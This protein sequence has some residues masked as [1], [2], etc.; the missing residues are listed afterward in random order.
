[1]TQHCALQRTSLVQNA[2]AR[3]IC[4]ASLTDTKHALLQNDF[5][6]MAACFEMPLNIDTFEGTRTVRNRLEFSKL[7]DDARRYYQSIGVTEISRSCVEAAFKDE[8]TVVA[9]HETRLLN[10]T[11]TLVDPYPVMAE[12]KWD[13]RGWKIVRNSYGLTSTDGLSRALHPEAGAGG[14][15]A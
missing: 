4:E 3:D 11:R 14:N 12:M 9:T 1:M 13:K 2:P 7:F 6:L 15:G 10:G 5:N 8:K